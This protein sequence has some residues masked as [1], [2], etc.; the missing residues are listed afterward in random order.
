MKKQELNT[1][2]KELKFSARNKTGTT[3]GITKRKFQDE[4]WKN[5]LMNYF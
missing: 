1:Q 5:Y 2:Q 3:I 4:E